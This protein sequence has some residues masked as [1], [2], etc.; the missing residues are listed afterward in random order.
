MCSFI[1][2]FPSDP[3]ESRDEQNRLTVTDGGLLNHFGPP[4][5][6]ACRPASVPALTAARPRHPAPPGAHRQ[7]CRVTG[8]LPGD[9]DNA[10]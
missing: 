10:R 6:K 3:V 4:G 9:R 5:I 1:F 2:G 7:R 8:L